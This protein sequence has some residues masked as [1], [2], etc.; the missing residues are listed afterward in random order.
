MYT[1]V[2]PLSRK[3][4]D[5]LSQESGVFTF[6]EKGGDSELWG[7]YMGAGNVFFFNVLFLT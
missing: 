4:R 3:A 6:R 1:Q 5:L 2:A 7:L